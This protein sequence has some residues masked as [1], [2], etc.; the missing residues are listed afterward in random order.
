MRL[1][2]KQIARIAEAL[3]EALLGS[4]GCRLLAERGPALACIEKVIRSSQAQE[5][6]L[7]REA[8]RLLEAYRAQAPGVDPQKMLA[9]IKKKLAEEKGIPL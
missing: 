2:D 5:A 3:L 4:G 7:D 8:E 9:M 1:N 6:D